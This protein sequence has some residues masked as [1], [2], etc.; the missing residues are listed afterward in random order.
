MPRVLAVE[1]S[2]I[3][4]VRGRLVQR[5]IFSDD[6]IVYV[7]V[8]TGEVQPE[9]TPDKYVDLISVYNSS[10]KNT[11]NNNTSTNESV[12]PIATKA[13]KQRKLAADIDLAIVLL[14]ATIGLVVLTEGGMLIVTLAWTIPMTVMAYKS[15][16]DNRERVAL[17]VCHLIFFNIISGIL[18]L[19]S[20]S[21][22]NERN[23]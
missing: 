1:E 23:G 21:N 5:V 19:V 2:E 12:Q 11:R 15:V 14:L 8:N 4:E 20:N 3:K 18:I 6:K 7:D 9:S 10:H 16:D 17:G 13:S 22:I